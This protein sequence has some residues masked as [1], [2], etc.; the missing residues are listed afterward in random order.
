LA[1]KFSDAVWFLLEQG[2][3]RG[4]S[5]AAMQGVNSFEGVLNGLRF[6]YDGEHSYK[7][8]VVDTLDALEPLVHEH[9]CAKHNWKNIEQPSYGKGWGA[10]DETWRRFLNAIISARNKRGMTIAMTA[11]ATIERVDDPRTPT[12]TAYGYGGHFRQ[13]PLLVCQ[14]GRS[15]R[16]L[17]FRLGHLACRRCLNATY[18]SRQL[19]KNNRPILQAKRLQRLLELKK[20]MWGS[21]RRRL[22]SRIATDPK[23]ELKSKRL[24]HH[25]IQLPQGNHGTR[26][27]MHWR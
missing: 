27:A 3:P 13:R 16:R 23:R 12:Y 26:G 1:S 7:T 24:A 17:Y 15:V 20:V 25:S 10:A 11:H 2:L 14:C 5:V 22:Q 18:A 19:S 9:T 6:L 8:L 4:V 21:N